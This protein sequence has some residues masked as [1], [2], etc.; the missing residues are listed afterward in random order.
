MGRSFFFGCFGE[1]QQT[2][3]LQK[4]L[5]VSTLHVFLDESGNLEFSPKGSPF[6]VFAAAW[7]YE[8]RLLAQELMSFRFKLLRDGHDLDS[9]H[10]TRDKQP[11]RDRVV[12]LLLNH[13]DWTFAS[14]VIE[15]AKVYPPLRDQIRFYPEFAA[16]LLRFVL[17]GRVQAGT[18]RVL[19][20]TDRLPVQRNTR[21]VEKAIKTACRAE[22]SDEIAF[23]L[24]HHPRQSNTWLQV[25]DYCCW[26]VHRKWDGKDTRTYDLLKR[27][28]AKLELEVTRS[29]TTRYY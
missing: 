3:C 17:R 20:Y 29:G 22:L 23:H 25:V 9:F 7:T 10:A 14:L 24:Y 26:A 5:P 4:L 11:H 28:I 21:A 6:Y 18:E 12:E 8:P 19:I 13:R 2:I 15:K 27:R 16:M 1:P